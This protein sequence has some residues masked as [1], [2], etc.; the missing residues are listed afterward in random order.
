MFEKVFDYVYQSAPILFF[1]LERDGRIVDMN[2]FA[3]GKMGPL[4]P[5]TFFPDLIVDFESTLDLENL[6]RSSE[7]EHM[8]TLNTPEQQLQSFLF[9]FTLSNS[10]IL[11]F[12]RPETKDLERMQTEMMALNRDFG[13]LN[14]ELQ[15][16][17]AELQHALDHVKTLQGIIPICMHCHKIR[18]DKQIWDRLEAYLSEHTEAQ[19][20][21]GI[22]PECVE[23]YYSDLDDD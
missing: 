4:S 8:L 9:K 10:H 18:N 12:G 7:N 13:N 11:A 14:R 5:D 19:L 21:H 16:K 3:A 20:S 1:R 6:V 2:R 22:C 23:K 15:K 17:N